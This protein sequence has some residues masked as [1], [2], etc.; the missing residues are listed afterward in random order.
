MVGNMVELCRSVIWLNDAFAHVTS[1]M[2]DIFWS[3]IRLNHDD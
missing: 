2:E 3:V 1:G